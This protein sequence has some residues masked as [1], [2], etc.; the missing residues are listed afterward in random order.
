MQSG[1]Y[2]EWRSLREGRGAA[3]RIV[4]ACGGRRGTVA[5]GGVGV[6]ELYAVNGAA[7][8]SFGGRPRG[9]NF[10]PVL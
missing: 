10:R 8:G 3:S 4:G 2:V 7:M 1:R 9:C 5:F 6:G